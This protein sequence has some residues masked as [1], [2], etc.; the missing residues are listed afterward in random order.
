MSSNIN[1]YSLLNSINMIGRIYVF[2]YEINKSALPI[3]IQQEVRLCRSTI[4]YVLWI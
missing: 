4:T 2:S 1:N 3:T